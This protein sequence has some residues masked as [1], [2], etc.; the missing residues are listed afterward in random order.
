MLIPDD[1]KARL[2][3]AAT[4]LM[5]EQEFEPLSERDIEIWLTR[6]SEAVAQRAKD[7]QN[8]MFEKYLA[9]QSSIDSLICQS[10]YRRIRGRH[11]TP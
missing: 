10:V 8:A 7:L 11:T 1:V 2:I 9:R 3:E 6:N 4:E 5:H